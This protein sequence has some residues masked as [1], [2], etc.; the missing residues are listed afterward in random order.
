MVDIKKHLKSITKQLKKEGMQEH[1]IINFMK[2]YNKKI[3]IESKI[4]GGTMGVTDKSFEIMKNLFDER[5]YSKLPIVDYLLTLDLNNFEATKDAYNKM[6]IIDDSSSKHLCKMEKVVDGNIFKTVVQPGEVSQTGQT[7]QPNQEIFFNFLGKAGA[8][9]FIYSVNDENNFS[10]ITDSQKILIMK[11]MECGLQGKIPQ[12]L[13]IK[14]IKT[15]NTDAIKVKINGEDRAL[16]SSTNN[17]VNQTLM[18]TIISIIFNKYYSTYK[19][20]IEQYDAFI[21][22]NNCYNIIQ[23]ANAGDLCDYLDFETKQY[24]KDEQID[25]KNDEF[26]INII[27]QVFDSLYILKQEPF[28]FVH[29][30]LKCKNVFVNRTDKGVHFNI[31]DYDKSSIYWKKIRFCPKYEKSI[32]AIID[33]DTIPYGNSDISDKIVPITTS[34]YGALLLFDGYNYPMFAHVPFSLSYDL[35]T[36]MVSLLLEP[37]FYEFIKSDKESKMLKFWQSMWVGNDKDYET[38]MAR[39]ANIYEA[40]R[41]LKRYAPTQIYTEQINKIHRGFLLG[42]VGS[43]V[44]LKII[45]NHETVLDNFYKISEQTKPTIINP[46]DTRDMHESQN[47]HDNLINTIQQKNIDII[48]HI[49]QPSNEERTYTDLTLQ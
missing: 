42:A 18:H 20:F 27:K 41:L 3:I 10:N 45:K 4:F 49:A 11:K 5:L 24:K 46:Q 9:G 25:T 37:S 13:E 29:A 1:Q 38:I 40:T 21:C 14:A 23:R 22:G 36:F 28:K 39:L 26:W 6:F 48:E 19:G 16:Y 44:D 15:E 17:F 43:L 8:N 33:H 7:S 12:K 30:D 2:N 31:A 32:D 34:I 47:I 35:Y